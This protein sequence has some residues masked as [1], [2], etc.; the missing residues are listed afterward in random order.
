MALTS[1]IRLQKY[2]AQC[3]VASRRGA[4][5]LIRDGQ[6]S[7]DGQL[8]TEMGCKIDPGRQIV[9]LR[10]TIVA[11]SGS[12]LVYILLNK[13][14]GYVTTMSDPQG[15]PIVTSLL[16]DVFVRVFPVG[17]L[18]IDTEGAL[19]LTNDGQLTHRVLHP[20]HQTNKTYE[21]LVQGYPGRHSLAELEQGILLE[22]QR[23]WPASIKLIKR[24][25]RTTKLQIIIHE[26][27]KR[28]VRKMFAAIG[29]PVLH[30][31]RI[32]YGKLQLGSL[33]SGGYRLLDE[34]DLKK[35]F[36]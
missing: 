22:G 36:L 10:D 5:D 6:V 11:P 19:L 27:R 34:N 32:A 8:V 20:S 29:H 25:Q 7:V 21:A 28:Q 17:R 1:T 24:Y 9:R 15:R 26:G 13:P 33:P 35:I 18:D 30:L 3:G 4:E 16:K 31:K 23:T 14:A 2:L 12:E